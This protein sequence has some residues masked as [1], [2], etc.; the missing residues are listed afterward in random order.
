MTRPSGL[1]G[2]TGGFTI[3]DLER[4]CPIEL[5]GTITERSAWV[6][7]LP[8]IELHL[9]L[10]GA[11]R[12]DTVAAL[13][14]NRS[15]WRDP[16]EPGWE[17]AYYTYRDFA[18]F[19]AQLTPRFPWLPE[20]YGRI[21]WECF[22][23]L[24]RS[25]VVYAEVSFDAPVD[26]VGDESRF[27]PIVEALEEARRRAE[28]RWPIR[29]NF[30]LGLQRRMPVEVAMYRVELAAQARDKGIAVAGIDLH[31]DEE[32]YPP[33]PFAPAFHLARDLGLGLRAHAGEAAGPQSV[34]D[35]IGILGVR[36][37]AHGVHAVED[38]ALIAR[39]RRGDVTLEMCPTSNIR[40]GVIAELRSHPLPLLY[41]L[42]IPVTINSDDPLPFSTNIER[43]YR[44]LVDEFGF[45]CDDLRTVTT[46]AAR[47]AFLSEGERQTLL[48]LIDGAYRTVERVLSR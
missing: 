36:R 10:E 47:A 13:T 44:L 48:T 14:Y 37:I 34:W 23:D 16:L 27:W 6:T 24:T 5:I 18:G 11:M 20:E 42:G 46:Y 17:H 39:L 15:G 41:G 28:H 2:A 38:P 1:T 7:T 33:A 25:C 35:A 30:I 32:H 43:E 3:L 4:S 21:A 9:H 12:P 45:S 19:M 26:V 40:T 31:G 8:K 22:E 29:I